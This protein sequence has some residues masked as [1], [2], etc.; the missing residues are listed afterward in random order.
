M[1]FELN[2]NSTLNRSTSQKNTDYFCKQC[3]CGFDQLNDYLNHLYTDEHQKYTGSITT[4]APQSL[5]INGN[6]V[7]LDQLNIVEKSPLR[8]FCFFKLFN[9]NLLKFF[10][11][12]C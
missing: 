10:R 11:S 2:K 12:R 5:N 7:F 1:N 6:N 4:A 3:C 8:G 9:S